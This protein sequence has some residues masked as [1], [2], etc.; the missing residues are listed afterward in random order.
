[1]ASL[2]LR[3][4]LILI[5]TLGL[6]VSLAASLGVLLRVEEQDLRREAGQRTAALLSAL[7]AP[8]SVLLT[9][10]RVADLDNLMG[11]LGQRTASLQLDGI[12]LVDVHGIVLAETRAAVGYGTN[13]ASADPFVKAAIEA[14][15]A[16]QDPAPPARPRRVSVPVQTGVRWATLI[17]TLD[18]EQLQATLVERRT[19]L[20]TSA[21]AVSSLGLLVLL[22][23]LSWE[24]LNPMADI[25]RMAERL[26][27]GD[28]KARAPVRG[29]SELQVLAT[30]LNEAARQ[31]GTNQER[32][33]SEVARRTEE[34][35]QANERLERLALTDPLTGLFNR[36]YLEQALDLEITRQRRQKRPFSLLMIDVDHFKQYNDAHGHPRGDEVLRRLAKIFHASLRAS[37]IIARIGGEE[38]VVLL[39]DVELPTA[40]AAAEKV[41]EAVAEH[42]FPFGEQQPLGRVTVSVGVASWPKHGETAEEVLAAADRALYGSKA[43]GR[44]RVTGVE[45]LPS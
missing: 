38:F 18:E 16:L 37:D 28:L 39:L 11:E 5:V 13:L 2:G 3:A 22:L 15:R 40:R 25:A 4:R 20:L 17:G 21:V 12:V 19:R 23:L 45:E 42:A 30:T 9:Q 29:A 36:R 34:L 1:M 32:L 33:E 14:P 26:V 43:A 24:V 10:G 7:A 35:S 8:T 44:N 41:R 31:L 6:G 27:H